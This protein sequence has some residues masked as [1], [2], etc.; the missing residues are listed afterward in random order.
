M[1]YLICILVAV[2]V[3]NASRYEF[4]A[5]ICSIGTVVF[6]AEFIISS[7]TNV[8]ID[9]LEFNVI[10]DSGFLI[11]GSTPP[12]I[13]QPPFQM[14]YPLTISTGSYRDINEVS[15]TIS[16]QLTAFVNTSTG[17]EAM[18]SSSVTLYKI[19]SE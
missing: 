1:F 14:S 8:S 5:N 11:N 6:T 12:F 7:K 16:F 9:Y 4:D 18:P 10:G 3:F 15:E 17:A 13:V 2:A 19:T